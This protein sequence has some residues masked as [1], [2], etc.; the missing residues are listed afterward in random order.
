MNSIKSHFS[1]TLIRLSFSC[2]YSHPSDCGKFYKCSNGRGYLFDCPAGEVW[3]VKLDRCDYFEL[4]G[5]NVDGTH[6]YK[7]KKMSVQAANIQQLSSSP[8][9][10]DN[11]PN[12]GEFEIDP[13][14]EGS[15]PI[16]PT[17]LPHPGDCTKFYKCYMGK[18][19]VIK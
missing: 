19:Y 17:H 1:S 11:E 18:A 15:D 9:A 14:C 4:V 12:L 13:R 8:S 16:K 3:S 5:C 10:D 6:Q 7:L 2:S